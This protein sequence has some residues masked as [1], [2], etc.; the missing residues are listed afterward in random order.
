MRRHRPWNKLLGTVNLPCPTLPYRFACTHCNLPV[1]TLQ[2]PPS[3]V[4]SYGHPSLGLWKAWDIQVFC[5][6]YFAD[7]PCSYSCAFL[8]EI[9]EDRNCLSLTYSKLYVCL[10]NVRCEFAS[11]RVIYWTTA[12]YPLLC[13]T[14]YI[15]YYNTE[16]K[17]VP[18]R[19]CSQTYWFCQ[20][21]YA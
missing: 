15:V 1:H 9:E 2:N 21:E 12:A 14:K 5:S 18:C 16:L 8:V 17:R 20:I 11:R 4:I 13:Q 7:R 10:N 6:F 19:A 3:P